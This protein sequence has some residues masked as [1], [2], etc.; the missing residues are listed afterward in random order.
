MTW[1]ILEPARKPVGWSR[2]GQEETAGN[3][4]GEVDRED[5]AAPSRPREGGAPTR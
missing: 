1:C 5:H 4:A 3:E 2:E